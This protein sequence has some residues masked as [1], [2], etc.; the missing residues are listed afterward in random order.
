MTAL[1]AEVTIVKADNS[2]SDELVAD[3]KKCVAKLE[4]VPDHQKD[5]HP[6]SDNQVLDLLHPSLF[7]V[8]FG[9]TRA[10]PTG[11]VPLDDAIAYT[12]R[13]ELTKD[14]KL[15]ST[16]RL[17]YGIAQHQDLYQ[18]LP[19]EVKLAQDGTTN[20]TSY[21][22]NLHPRDHKELYGVLEKFVAASVPLWEEVLT[23]W[24]DLRRYKFTGTNDEEDYYIPE[25]LVYEK[26]PPDPEDLED[27]DYEEE[28]PDD[29]LYTEEYQD[30]VEEHRILKF[31][32]PDEF[33]SFDKKTKSAERVH[34]T[35]TGDDAP[36]QFPDGLQVIFK[37]ANI[38]LTPEKP[39]YAGGSW[40]IE[41][42]LSERICATALYY[43]DEENITPSRLA[44]RQGID[45]EEA[46][47]YPMQNA[48]SSLESYLGVQQDGPAIQDLGSVLTRPGRLLAFPN[49]L[50]HR[51]GSFELEDKTKP[52][53]RMILAMFLIDPHRRILSS[54]NVPPQRK[55]WWS[56]SVHDTPALNRLPN[57]LFSQVIDMVD[58]FP[59]SWESAV[60]IRADLM[61]ERS[62]FTEQL[63][64]EFE[65]VSLFPAT[66]KE[67]I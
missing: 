65:E 64:G 4:D 37:L 24:G 33:D 8:V 50:Q 40:H 57:E 56:E 59:L 3:L 48:Y 66:P 60:A 31:P 38:H 52:G 12:G 63:E 20:I 22:N 47:M 45:E 35:P 55:D 23:S 36:L 62:N 41:G 21:I 15:E 46:I 2:V 49:V 26:P 10:L 14:E 19:S 1:D 44:F 42:T 27:P 17:V 18:W 9:V 7:P 28:D 67:T 29:Y 16:D 13:G 5:W 54:A 43:Y 39:S 58:S 34:L 51:V 25:G 32:E 11:T 6:G 53:H 61:K 30:W